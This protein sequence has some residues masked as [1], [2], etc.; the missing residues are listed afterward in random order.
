MGIFNS[1]EYS[2]KDIHV[3]ALGRLITGI[4]EIQYDLERTVT[5]IYASGTKPH[6][7]TKGKKAFAGQMTVL[8]SEFEAMTE[9]A[10]TKFGPGADITDLDFNT[11]V[12]YAMTENEIIDAT[13]KIKTDIL[14]NVCV[15]KFQK[16]MGTEDTHM[17]V[18]LTLNIG[19]ITFN[20]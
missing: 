11:T 16:K 13:S 4:T 5:N 3:T 2:W 10:Q 12:S 1:Q 9:A 6:S 18:V 17:L 19:D 20:A 7:R 14:Q 8:Q 15:T